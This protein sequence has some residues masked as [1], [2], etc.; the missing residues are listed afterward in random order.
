M[1]GKGKGKN[2]GRERQT[3]TT[4]DVMDKVLDI[5]HTKFAFTPITPPDKTLQNIK[6]LPI[7]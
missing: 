4:S 2:M 6:S 3:R 5:I 7:F 1:S